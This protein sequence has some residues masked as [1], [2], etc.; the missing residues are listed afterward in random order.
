MPAVSSPQ[1]LAEYLDSARVRY[2][3]LGVFDMDGVLRG[4]YVDREKL[5]SAAEK[6]MGFCDVVLGWD[7]ADQLYDNTR[8]SG[9]HTGYRDAEVQLDL[10]TL[11][12]IPFEPDTVLV[13]G[14]FA[15]D[16]AAACPRGLL[17]RVVDKARAMGFAVFAAG[18]YEFFLFDETPHSAREKGYRNLR[19]LTPG[20]FGYSVLRGSV[21]HELHRDLIDTM[22]GLD[23]ALEGLH[24]E[25]GPG[26]LEAAIR[27]DEALAAADKAALFKTFTKVVAQRRGLMATFMAKWSDDLPGQSGHIHMSLRDASGANVFFDPSAEHGMSA[28]LRHFIGGQQR[29]MPELLALI[30]PTVNAY[31]RLV[32]GMWAPT[33]SNWGVENRTTALRVI[34]AGAGGTRVEVRVA[35]ADAN[36]YLAMAAALASGLWGIEHQVEPPPPVGGNAYEDP[37][38]GA[39]PL[40]GTLG[41]A[42]AALR[43]SEAAAQLLGDVFVDHFAS[44]REW[45][46][47]QARRAVTDWDL[48]RYFEII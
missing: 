43:A 25:T 8:L 46:D 21:H 29:L 24:T 35:P 42:A 26:V 37:G 16:Y 34:P 44:T 5:L 1:Q 45:E 22:A 38:P 32:P 33:H 4:K 7:S 31:R 2:H 41:E 40:P 14:G 36:P 39:L 6:G 20:M 30:C 27:Y 48:A 13:L 28:T 19:P 11:R 12:T 15:G 23:C 17:R 47:R 9:W 10:S 18:E 3:K